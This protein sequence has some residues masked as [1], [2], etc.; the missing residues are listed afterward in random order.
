MHAILSRPEFV[1]VV[2]WM[3]HGRSWRVLKPREFEVRVI[4]TYFEHQKFS[5]FIRQAN[6]WGFRRISQGKD[7][8]SYYH[9]LFLRGLPHLAKKMKRPGVSKKPTVDADHEPNFYEIS[10]LHPLPELADLENGGGTVAGGTNDGILLSGFTAGSAT[11][12][13]NGS[14][15]GMN[16]SVSNDMNGSILGLAGGVPTSPLMAPSVPNTTSPAAA[17]LAPSAMMNGLNLTN[18][19]L[20]SANPAAA[21]AVSVATNTTQHQASA[22]PDPSSDSKPSASSTNQAMTAATTLS[23]LFPPAQNVQPTTLPNNIMPFGMLSPAMYQVMNAAAVQPSL[24]TLQS[25]Q[26]QVQFPPSSNTTNNSAITATSP[27]VAPISTT[28]NFPNPTNTTAYHAPSS[29]PTAVTSTEPSQIFAASLAANQHAIQQAALSSIFA[30]QA[31]VAQQQQQQQQQGHP[32]SL[33]QQQQQQ[34]SDAIS[35]FAAGFAAATALNNPQMYNQWNQTCLASTATPSIPLPQQQQQQQQHPQFA[36]ASTMPLSTATGQ[37]SNCST[38]PQPSQS[39]SS[40]SSLDNS[41]SFSSSEK[42]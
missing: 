42:R 33:Q 25:S 16:T 40:S 15:F 24:S 26:Q 39:S 9:E 37:D 13:V 30:I 11:A 5:S 7:R 17:G 38:I 8:N 28:N 3:P 32:Q 36:A 29:T 21:S 19:P 35:Q 1:D 18:H 20:P 2:S 4:P 22:A 41:S 12:G 10:A 27:V 23:S 14:M 31:S 6:G 34:A